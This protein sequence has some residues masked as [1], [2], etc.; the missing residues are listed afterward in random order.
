MRASIHCM[1]IKAYHRRWFRVGGPANGWAASVAGSLN[2][3]GRCDAEGFPV[4]RSSLFCGVEQPAQIDAM[5]ALLDDA[6]RFDK[7]DVSVHRQVLGHQ[8][9]GVETQR[10]QAQTVGLRH[11]VIDQAPA[12]AAALTRRIDANVL[13]EVRVGLGPG[14]Q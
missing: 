7:A 13:D 5:K 10:G 11:R 8:C 12:Q 9:V 4:V 2:H 14:N 1:L 6:M 3:E